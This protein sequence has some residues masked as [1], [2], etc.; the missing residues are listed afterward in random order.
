MTM[1]NVNLNHP[2][3]D[4]SA[5]INGKNWDLSERSERNQDRRLFHETVSE[6]GNKHDLNN[7]IIDQ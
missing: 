1:H 3:W 6:C 5:E 4:S 7:E 2:F